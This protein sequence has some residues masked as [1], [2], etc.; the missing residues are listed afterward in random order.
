MHRRIFLQPCPAGEN[1]FTP[2]WR[3]RWTCAKS[4]GYPL[5]RIMRVCI[6]GR[7]SV[8]N[9]LNG[10]CGFGKRR[11]RTGLR[12]LKFSPRLERACSRVQDGPPISF[13]H[14]SCVWRVKPYLWC[15]VKFRQARF[16]KASKG[17]ILWRDFLHDAGSLVSTVTIRNS[18]L[19]SDVT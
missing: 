1:L 7:D 6:F 13:P 8:T 12:L 15:C 16:C 14:N 3:A 4:G 19:S 17:H 10:T 9:S 18:R 2:F 5:H 11:L